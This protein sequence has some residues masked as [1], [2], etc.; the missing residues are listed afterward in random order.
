MI[1]H[2]ERAS[3]R[4]RWDGSGV[5]HSFAFSLLLKRECQGLLRSL[6]RRPCSILGSS[7]C[8]MVEAFFTCL[9][10][11]LLCGEAPFEELVLGCP[12]EGARN[13]ARIDFFAVLNLEFMLVEA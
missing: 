3:E 2:T 8:D 12:R 7:L 6:H 9:A 5:V 1:G 11:Q 10:H 4:G 13:K